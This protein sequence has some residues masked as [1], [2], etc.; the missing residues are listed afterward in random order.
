MFDHPV[1]SLRLILQ[2][3]DLVY[4]CRSAISNNETQATDQYGGSWIANVT[5]PEDHGT[6]HI[7]IIDK[8][9]MAVG[10]TTSVNTAFGS[11]VYSD[12]TG[13]SNKDKCIFIVWLEVQHICSSSSIVSTTCTE[14]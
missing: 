14:S 6:S 9:R 7:S 5:N 13:K 2:A 11:F 4:T 10:M 3:E 1:S 8:Q 12:S